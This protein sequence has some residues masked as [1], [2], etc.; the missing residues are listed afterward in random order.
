MLYSLLCLW[1]NDAALFYYMQVVLTGDVKGKGLKGDV[2]SVANGYARNFLMAKGL[3]TF[4]TADSV[5]AAK[6]VQAERVA[7]RE[8]MIKEA[9]K[10][11]EKINTTT[12]TFQH[13]VASGKKLFAGVNEAEVAAALTKEAKVAIEKSQIHF[14]KGH[15]KTIGEHTADVHVFG[16]HHATVKIVVEAE[17]S[18]KK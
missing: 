10:Y 3:A 5:F 1:H 18:D 12:L 13:K 15:P 17:E 4:A 8:Q 16:E 7:K 11:V 9:T 14:S 6:A 2:I